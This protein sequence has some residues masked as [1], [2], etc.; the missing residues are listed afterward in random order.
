MTNNLNKLFDDEDYVEEVVRVPIDQI[1]HF[2]KHPF[3]INWDKVKELAESMKDVGQIIPALIRKD[4]DE[5]GAELIAGHHRY[6]A[7]KLLGA[8]ELNCIYRNDLTDDEIML[9][10]IDSNLQRGFEALSHSERASVIYERHQAVSK[11]GIRMDLV[12]EIE[13]IERIAS[14]EPYDSGKLLEDEFELSPR[15]IR[16]YLRIYEL[17]DPLKEALDNGIISKRVAVDLSYAGEENQLSIAEK[18]ISKAYKIDMHKADVLKSY[19]KAESLTEEIIIEILED[20]TKA[21]K[22]KSERKKISIQKTIY[23]KYFEP[24]AKE[25]EINNIIE[26]ALELYFNSANTSKEE[27]YSIG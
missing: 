12:K 27:E 2:K 22:A 26:K 8:N 17:V 4:P 9:M 20:K 21:K 1:H 23:N 25:E 13:E 7:V 11:R 24:K 14:E 5:P 3:K 16:R 18:I 10:V 6:E 15:E 19:A